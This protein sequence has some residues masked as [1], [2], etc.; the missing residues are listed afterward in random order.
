MLRAVREQHLE[1]VV[2]KRRDS[3]YE[4][5]KRTGAWIKYRVNRGQ[6]LAICGYLPGPHGVDSI[7]VGYYKEEDLVSV[8]R[9]RNGLYRLRA[10]SYFTGSMVWQ[11]QSARRS[12]CPA[13]G[14]AA[15][16]IGYG[17]RI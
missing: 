1:G 13:C 8:A 16:L 15:D 17:R 11:C 12:G 3:I 2:G 9:V 7:I 10:V 5:G 14:Q 4:E 6:E